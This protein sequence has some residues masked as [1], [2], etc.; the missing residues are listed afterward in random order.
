MS[1]L[2][3]AQYIGE[4][5]IDDN[6]SSTEEAMD[7]LERRYHRITGRNMRI[8]SRVV[9]VAADFVEHTNEMHAKWKAG[10]ADAGAD[11]LGPVIDG[12]AEFGRD[13]RPATFELGRGREHKLFVGMAAFLNLLSPHDR[14]IN[15]SYK[16]KR[17]TLI[18]E[19][20]QQIALPTFEELSSRPG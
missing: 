7:D 6:E 16:G 19:S 10:G 2:L 13:F 5:P 12:I 15:L 1:A 17:F 4:L 18:S 8:D 14:S 9:E 3:M 20:A 11:A